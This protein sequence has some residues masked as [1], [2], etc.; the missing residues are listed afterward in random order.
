MAPRGAV[1]PVFRGF[2]V[3]LQELARSSQPVIEFLIDIRSSVTGGPSILCR[4][5]EGMRS[6]TTTSGSRFERYQCTNLRLAMLSRWLLK[7][8]LAE[9]SGLEHFSLVANSNAKNVNKAFN[10]RHWPLRFTD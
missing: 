2:N 5:L 10:F 3:V 7:F 4:G 8:A 6:W 1:K 9:A